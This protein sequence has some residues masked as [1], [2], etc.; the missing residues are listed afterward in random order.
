MSLRRTTLPI[1]VAA[2]VLGVAAVAAFGGGDAVAGAD[3]RAAGARAVPADAIAYASVAMDRQGA[4]WQALERL[5][6]RVPGGDEAIAQFDAMLTEQKADGLV[7]ALG[8]DIAVGLLGV[9]LV[10]T[11]G[12][13]A[14][15]VLV[16]TAAD[17]PR[18]IEA[19]EAAGFTGG[20]ALNGRP[21]WTKGAT[22]VTV[23][24]RTVLVGTSRAGLRSA[25]AAAAGERPAL[26]DDPAFTAT[27]ADLPNDPLAVAYLSPQRI[28]G[29]VGAAL[30]LLPAEATAQAP[31][32]D[33]QAAEAQ[34]LL[35]AI[36][37][38]GIAVRAEE[39]GLRIAVAGD[40]D[41]A[42]LDTALGARPEAFAPTLL[43]RA[44]ADAAAVL[45]LQDLG[46]LLQGAL[47]AAGS[48]TGLIAAV[49][50]ATGLSFDDAIVPA[51]T[52]QHVGVVRSGDEPT[53]TLLLAPPDAPQAAA[54][55]ERLIEAGSAEGLPGDA[56]LP[57]K[58]RERMPEVAV[59]D[60]V[61]AVGD[62]PTLATAPAASLTSSPAYRAAA[63]AAGLPE[64]VTG[65][66][67]V[68][69][70]AA[71][72]QAERVADAKGRPLPAATAALGGVIGWGTDRGAELFIVVG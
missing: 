57:E 2:L 32:L 24:G 46:P 6:G 39:G 70:A 41:Q 35:A 22:T 67:Y 21:T 18:V 20:P 44:P 28:A 34:E 69:G 13:R 30:A 51:L 50:A 71:R 53:A 45:A 26:A 42:A 4:P 60:G 16:A 14:D 63:R 43:D 59:A 65:V 25:L 11:D 47:R 64:R 8:G 48:D 7:E 58:L 38:L 52:G 36:R 37:G 3:E 49:E 54:T 62:E 9:E 56:R 31:G 27:I 17:G 10:G 33:A 23:G 15:A 40:A 5:A 68:D 29:L 19:I 1:V 72:A 61:V 55:L 12:P 66:V